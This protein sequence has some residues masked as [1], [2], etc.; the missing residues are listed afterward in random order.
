MQIRVKIQNFSDLNE[1]CL[2]SGQLSNR[3]VHVHGFLFCLRRKFLSPA[4]KRSPKSID[5]PPVLKT[6][7]RIKGLPSLK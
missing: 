4:E 6:H 5:V 2:K 7:P 3:F 1:I